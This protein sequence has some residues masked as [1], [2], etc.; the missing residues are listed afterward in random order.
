MFKAFIIKHNDPP[1]KKDNPHHLLW[2]KPGWLSFRI[3]SISLD[4]AILIIS[5]SSFLISSLVKDIL[6]GFL[7]TSRLR[8]LTSL[9]NFHSWIIMVET[10]KGSRLK[11]SATMLTFP[12][13]VFQFRIVI[14]EKFHPP[15]LSN[16]QFL[17]AEGTF[18]AYVVTGDFEFNSIKAVPPYF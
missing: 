1:L 3:T 12:L 14:L 2:E 15:S 16:V 10:H 5:L 4:W 9:S 6:E 17:L 13:V 8:T 7:E 18:K 11:A